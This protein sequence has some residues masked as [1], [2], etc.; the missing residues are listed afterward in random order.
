MFDLEIIELLKKLKNTSE[1][2]ESKKIKKSICNLIKE[3]PS[4][5]EHFIQMQALDRETMKIF[6]ECESIEHEEDKNKTN[7]TSDFEIIK[8]HYEKWLE[9]YNQ[10]EKIPNNQ[11]EKIIEDLINF[12]IHNRFQILLQILK[13]NDEDGDFENFKNML[14]NYLRK[15]FAEKINAYYKSENYQTLGFLKKREKNREL[16]LALDNIGHYNFDKT[17]INEVLK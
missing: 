6:S 11:N 4:K 10:N 1:E 12:Y 17:M 14:K 16:L 13:T 7:E 5:Y 8:K 9:I 3:N 15:Y 2:Y